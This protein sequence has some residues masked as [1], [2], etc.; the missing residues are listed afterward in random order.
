MLRWLMPL[1]L[2][3]P[4]VCSAVDKEIVELQRDIAL[5][6]DRVRTIQRSMDQK[7]DAMMEML[8][9][10]QDRVDEVQAA[11]GLI[12]KSLKERLS[13]PVAG[14]NVKLD[15]MSSNVLALKET[16]TDLNARL[17]RL[18]QQFTRHSNYL[19]HGLAGKCR[20]STQ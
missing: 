11:N 8:E 2:A 16:I 1:M 5:V 3:F 7:M 20:G 9:S 10:T 12:D 19:I 4:L 17:G 13:A 6:D 18:E 14:M 15:R